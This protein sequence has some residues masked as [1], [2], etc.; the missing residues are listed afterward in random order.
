MS[1]SYLDLNSAE[2][3]SSVETNRFAELGVESVYKNANSFRYRLSL[4]GHDCFARSESVQ[5][6]RGAVNSGSINATSCIHSPERCSSPANQTSDEHGKEVSDIN[7]Y[8]LNREF[9][10]PTSSLAFLAALNGAVLEYLVIL[11][12]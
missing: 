7:T 12:N 3:S 9:R 10:G 11:K 4:D 2:I 8:I 1:Y 5:N 6:K